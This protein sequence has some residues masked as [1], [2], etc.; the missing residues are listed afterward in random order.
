MFKLLMT[1]KNIMKI[2]NLLILLTLE[3]SSP[4]IFF[5]KLRFQKSGEGFQLVKKLIIKL[6]YNSH[7]ST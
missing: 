4:L 5:V 1:I 6:F 3:S 2:L 7:L